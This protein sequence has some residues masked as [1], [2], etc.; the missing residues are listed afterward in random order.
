VKYSNLKAFEKSVESPATS[1]LILCKDD[2]Q[3]SQAVDFL[4]SKLLPS[5]NELKIYDGNDL[6]ISNLLDTLNTPSFFSPKVVALVTH[7]EKLSVKEHEQLIEY[8]LK[9]NSKAVLIFSAESIN[10]NL[11]FYKQ[12]EKNGVVLEIS[13]ADKPW[14][15]EKAMADWII[16]EIGAQNKR[17]DPLAAQ[18][19]VNQMGTSAALLHQEI[20]KL[21]CYVGD[22]VEIHAKDVA[23]ICDATNQETIWQLNDAILRCD[24]STALRITKNLMEDGL[25]L[26]V[27]LRQ[28]RTQFLNG[29]QI[30]SILANGGGPEEISHVL[31]QL[32]GNILNKQISSAQAYGLK[33]FKRGLIEI[34]D[35]EVDA[36]N[37]SADGYDLLA[38]RLIIK[39]CL[40]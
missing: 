11:K 5:K 12:L 32:R 31:P 7:A 21:I 33:N 37:S 14:E 38:E 30:T 17:I 13:I 6:S 28:I 40:R 2:Y 10:H 15:R 19:L 8:I 24:V 35:T 1:Y 22:R 18:Q 39:L 4:T 16:Q 25:V 27:L 34:D 29:F 36:K 3:R 26:L 20:E 9:P 23:A